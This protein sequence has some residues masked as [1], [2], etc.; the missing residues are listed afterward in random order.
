MKINAIY[1]YAALILGLIYGAFFFLMALDSF[2]VQWKSREIEGFLIH[3]SPS[4]IV[5]FCAILGFKKP[6][7]GVIIFLI[8]SIASILFFHTYRNVSHFMIVS[9]PALVLAL[10][11]LVSIQNKETKNVV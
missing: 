2:P 4:I 10:L 8:I 11:F 7:F 9:F 3:A 1:R 6:I 5:M